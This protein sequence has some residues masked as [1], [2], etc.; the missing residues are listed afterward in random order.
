[1]LESFLIS[2]LGEL[3]R[4]IINNLPT[5]ITGLQQIETGTIIDASAEPA[6][7]T[8]LTNALTQA[9]ANGTVPPP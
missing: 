4:Q 7:Q 6:V 2:L 9:I 3:F 1:M 5:I 8:E